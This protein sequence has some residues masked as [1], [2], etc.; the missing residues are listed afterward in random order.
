[1]GEQAL[2][3]GVASKG[4][5]VVDLVRSPANEETG[6]DSEQVLMT[7]LLACFIRSS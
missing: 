3:K 4:D 6:T 2:F 5:E 1:M 7:F